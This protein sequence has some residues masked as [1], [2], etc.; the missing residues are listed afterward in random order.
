MVNQKYF[1]YVFL[2]LMVTVM[3]S[4]ISFVLT[5]VNY[6]LQPDFLMVWGR[7]FLSSAMV[8][9]PTAFFIGP[10]IHRLALRIASKVDG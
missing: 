4:T 6:G 1:Q 3:G 2:A 5:L 10:L 8:A 7:S 9:A